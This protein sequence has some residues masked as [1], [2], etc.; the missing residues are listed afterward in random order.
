MQGQLN[1]MSNVGSVRFNT[2]LVACNQTLGFLSYESSLQRFGF[3]KPYLFH[4]YRVYNLTYTMKYLV[5]ED[6]L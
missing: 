3:V 2:G 6:C 5:V 4:V 1:A